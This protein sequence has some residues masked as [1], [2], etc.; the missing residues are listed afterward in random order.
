QRDRMSAEEENARHASEAE[1]KGEDGEG[2]A[3]Q[4]SRRETSSR[5]TV[6]NCWPVARTRATRS[7]V[8]PKP[9][10]IAV[11][12]RTWGMG[13]PPTSSW[14]T[15]GALRPKK[16]L[17]RRRK[18]F[19]PPRRRAKPGTRRIAS[20]WS[21]WKIPTAINTEKVAQRSQLMGSPLPGRGRCGGR[22]RASPRRG[23]ERS[24]PR[25]GG[26]SKGRS[27][28]LRGGGRRRRPG[29]SRH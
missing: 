3:H 8:T 15:E 21:R 6:S 2:G 11:R 4:C 25:R 22:V 7:A 13:S 10:A 14:T 29:G 24:R 9:M 1:E 27:R 28:Y 20:R 5:S 19:A 17:Q 12:I 18:R 16:A 23:R 26:C